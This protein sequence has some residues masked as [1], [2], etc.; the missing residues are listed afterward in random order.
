M[1]ILQ[2]L[3]VC[4][5]CR[6]LKKRIE[7]L[8]RENAQL[9]ADQCHSGYGD[10]YGNHRCKYQDEIEELE[11]NFPR[12]E[13]V[14]VEVARRYKQERDEARECAASFRDI[15]SSFISEDFDPFPWESILEEGR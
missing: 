9:A 5:N 15:A 3:G 10:P 6:E 2:K 11:A 12:G 13:V 8:E 7:E 4:P 1:S 14:P